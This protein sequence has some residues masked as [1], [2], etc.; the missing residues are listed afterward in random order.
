MQSFLC[1]NSLSASCTA[2]FIRN[3]LGWDFS[4]KNWFFK[5]FD[6]TLSPNVAC[7]VTTV[8]GSNKEDRRKQVRNRLSYN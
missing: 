8:S 4:Q 7:F 1:E 2:F 6:L 3:V 5:D